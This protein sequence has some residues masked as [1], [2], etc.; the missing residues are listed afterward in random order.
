[1]RE[2]RAGGGA[3]S[4]GGA[5]DDAESAGGGNGDAETARGEP[6][7]CPKDGDSAPKESRDADG[8]RPGTEPT[9]DDEWM[10]AR[11]CVVR[12]RP[13]RCSLSVERVERV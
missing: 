3:E 2:K 5:G 7:A 8:V 9:S 12:D 1:M 11:R 6:A 13:V 4:A 10:R